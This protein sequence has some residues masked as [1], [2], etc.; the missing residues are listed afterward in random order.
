MCNLLHYRAIINVLELHDFSTPPLSDSEDSGG[1]RS[2]S[3]LDDNGYDLGR[4][5]LDSW[6]VVRHYATDASPSVLP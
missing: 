5:L 6:P 2:G 4:G 3:G 1:W